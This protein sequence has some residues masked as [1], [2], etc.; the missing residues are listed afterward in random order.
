MP[1]LP[2]SADALSAVREQLRRKAEAAKEQLRRDADEHERAEGPPL[3]QLLRL[4][5]E[6][7]TR[8]LDDWCGRMRERARLRQGARP[9]GPRMGPPRIRRTAARRA[10]GLRSGQDPGDEEP[11]PEPALRAAVRSPADALVGGHNRTRR[12]P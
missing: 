6:T 1:S 8:V 10:A 5:Q 2:G 4:G 11:E 12:A 9:R 7:L 3:E